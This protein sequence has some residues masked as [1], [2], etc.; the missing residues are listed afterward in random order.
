MADQQQQQTAPTQ[1]DAVFGLLQTVR[2]NLRE[3]D[4]VIFAVL[5]EEARDHTSANLALDLSGVRYRIEAALKA[6]KNIDDLTICFPHD[7]VERRVGRYVPLE[8]AEG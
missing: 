7:K 2:N 1:K 3:A 6:V 4:D 5:F 8:K